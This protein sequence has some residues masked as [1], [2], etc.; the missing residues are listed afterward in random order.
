MFGI[1]YANDVFGTESGFEFYYFTSIMMPHLTFSL[2]E[3]WK[4]IPLSAAACVTFITQQIYGTGLLLDPI[5]APP[6]ERI[7]AIIIVV[8]FVITILS[9]A[10]WR[11]Y[12]AQLEVNLKNEKLLKATNLMALGEVSA[13]IAHEINNPLQSLSLNLSVMKEKFPNEEFNEHYQINEGLIQKLGKIVQG[14]KDLSRNDY[15]RQTEVFVFSKVV[16]DVL[17]LSSERIKKKNIQI[18]IN[19]DHLLKARAN[20]VQ[21]TQVLINLVNN[22]IDAVQ[23]LDERWI[24]I[25]VSQKNSV[26]QISI[27]DSGKGISEVVADNMMKP[28]YTTKGHSSGTGLGLSISKNIIEKNNGSLYYDS[29][30]A[31]TS[32]IILLPLEE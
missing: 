32:F 29:S 21:I 22:S 6:E 30:S 18:Y 7:I 23:E 12:N 13:G 24:R 4:G 16:E 8:L 11:L 5:T 27:S 26:L 31:N 17:V 20:Q 15:A 19:D 2:D 1:F 10:R 28:F 14:L 25:S 3:I 9:V